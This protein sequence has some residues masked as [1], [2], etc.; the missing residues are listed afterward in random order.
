MTSET[1]TFI[2]L[3]DITG[4]ELECRG[5][6]TRIFTP[7]H[8]RLDKIG[9]S[10][11]SCGNE[12]FQMTS[13]PRTGSTLCP[14]MDQLRAMIDKLRLL[15]SSDRADVVANIRLHVKGVSSDK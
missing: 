4:I 5:C 12:W 15:A 13:D 6:Q 10:C 14:A 1:R 2:E 9:V 8:V 3:R 7:L 11:P